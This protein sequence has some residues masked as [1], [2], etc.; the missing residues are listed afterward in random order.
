MRRVLPGA[1]RPVAPQALSEVAPGFAP[2]ATPVVLPGGSAMEWADLAPGPVGFHS[3]RGDWVEPADATPVGRDGFR[4][5]PGAL[6]AG[7]DAFR[8]GP[9]EFRFGQDG[10]P[11]HRGDSAEPGA[12]WRVNLRLD[13]RF[14]AVPGSDVPPRRPQDDPCSR[15]RTGHGSGTLRADS[16]AGW[17]WEACAAHAERPAPPVGVLR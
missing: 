16:G 11:V 12:D 17:S 9:D 15:C 10:L 13:A 2:G 4:V 8:S 5:A 3:E 6:P 14:P 1:V 7:P